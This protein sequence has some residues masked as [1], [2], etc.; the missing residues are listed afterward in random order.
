[1]NEAATRHGSLKLVYSNP[2][3]K[4][5]SSLSCWWYEAHAFRTQLSLSE[6]GH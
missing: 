4:I 6:N 5:P 2:P 1:M 3:V